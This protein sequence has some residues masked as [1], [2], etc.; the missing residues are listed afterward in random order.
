M[1]QMAREA[2]GVKQEGRDEFVEIGTILVLLK[3]FFG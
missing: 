1:P 2:P 3:M